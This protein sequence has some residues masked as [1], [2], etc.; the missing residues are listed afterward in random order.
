MACQLLSFLF[1]PLKVAQVT[2]STLGVPLSSVNVV[3]TNS[4][5]NPNGITTGGSV[6]SELNCL[7]SKL[8][9]ATNTLRVSRSHM[10]D[11]KFLQHLYLVAIM[12]AIH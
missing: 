2:A 12:H 4:F 1:L 10:K 9:P 3:P 8:T 11:D 5:T 7:V 6:A